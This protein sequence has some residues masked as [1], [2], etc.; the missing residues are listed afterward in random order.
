MMVTHHHEFKIKV[1]IDGP[2]IV[3][4]GIPLIDLTMETDE[5]G[6]STRWKE[7]QRYPAQDRYEL[8]RCGG[9]KD[10][11]FCDGTHCEFLFDGTETASREP[12]ITHAEPITAGPEMDLIDIPVLCASA[13]FCDRAG[14]AWDNTRASDNPEAKQI[15][16]QEVS[17][18]PA[19]RLLLRDK[20]GQ[21]I[22]PKFEPSIGVV[23]D[24]IINNIGPLWVRG[25]IPIEAADG[26]VYEIRN[27][28]TLC[29]CGK[30][31]N[32]P[33]CDGKHCDEE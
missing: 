31:T 30:S 8:C 33:F 22:E 6:L 13:R 14:G 29:R 15:A 12:V 18:C 28:V 3:T 9:S 5:Q 19:G 7:G 21:S 27:R 17:A 24:P 23:F 20:H 16:I 1:S 11:P 32:K 25:G 2:Y 26:H 4:G 10:K